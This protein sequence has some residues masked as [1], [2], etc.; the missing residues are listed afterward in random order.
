MDMPR[1]PVPPALL[2]MLTSLHILR[3]VVDKADQ[4]RCPEQR[5][6]TSCTTLSSRRSKYRVLGAMAAGPSCWVQLPAGML[7][8]VGGSPLLGMRQHVNSYYL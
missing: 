8:Q 6:I 5:R 2:V 1:L 4:R 7:L 3:Q